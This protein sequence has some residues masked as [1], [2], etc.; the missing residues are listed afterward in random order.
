[1]EREEGLGWRPLALRERTQLAN[2]QDGSPGVHC[3]EEGGWGI[4]PRGPLF[5]PGEEDGE[6]SH[7][8]EEERDGPALLLLE[9]ESEADGEHA[10]PKQ[11]GWKKRS[12]KRHDA[13]DGGSG[14]RGGRAPG[15]EMVEVVGQAPEVAVKASGQ[16]C[17]AGDEKRNEQGE[18]KIV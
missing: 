3:I 8:Q 4:A 14:K 7:A 9:I 6:L 2:P 11:G 10:A 1:G 12:Q 15:K 16:G 13:A 5:H 17:E 18:R